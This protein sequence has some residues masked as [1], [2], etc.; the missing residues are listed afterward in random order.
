MIDVRGNGGGYI[1]AAEFLLQLLTPRRINPEPV[2]LI[3]TPV[4]LELTAE[5]DW[6]GDW[7]DSLL[8]GVSTGAKYS[9]GIPLSPPDIVNSVG[10]VYHGPV[11]LITDAFCYSACDMF[12]AGFQDHEIGTI[13]GVDNATGAGGANVLGHEDL[14]QDWEEGPLRQLPA[15]AGMR[16]SLRRT[17]RVGDQVGQPIEDLGVKPDVLVDMTE[18]DLLFGNR[19]LQ[20]KAGEILAEGT[21]RRLGAEVVDIVGSTVTLELT[22][23]NI[24]EVDI[25]VDDRPQDSAETPDGTTTVA[26]E[27]PADGGTV[28]LEGFENGNLVGARQ[29]TFN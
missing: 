11:V 24:P 27:L 13:L 14:R 1:I 19:D 8:Q 3:N 4:T 10:Q 15:D 28:R 2:Q 23:L 29:L 9:R 5:V 16:V 12:A 7:H 6:M 20:N 22:T 17:L 18:D 25:Y 21:Q 26:V